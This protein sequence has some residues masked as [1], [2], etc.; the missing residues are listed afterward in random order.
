MKKNIIKR[1]NE[2]I[3]LLYVTLQQF[4]R[5]SETRLLFPAPSLPQGSRSGSSARPPPPPALLPRHSRGFLSNVLLR[6][7]TSSGLPTRS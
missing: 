6:S 7:F 5:K 1:K 4:W 2:I 3:T